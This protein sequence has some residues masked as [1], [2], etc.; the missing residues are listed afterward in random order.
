M[1]YSTTDT[2]LKIV[3]VAHY[4]KDSYCQCFFRHPAFAKFPDCIC[5]SLVGD[6]KINRFLNQFL[7]FRELSPFL[8]VQTEQLEDSIYDNKP[9]LLLINIFMGNAVSDYHG[10]SH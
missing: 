7:Q 1:I 8:E 2:F 10:K 9:E 6:S 5:I 4:A 3:Y